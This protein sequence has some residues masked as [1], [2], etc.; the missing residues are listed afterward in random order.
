MHFDTFKFSTNVFKFA[1]YLSPFIPVT[2]LSYD[3]CQKLY[4]LYNL[5]KRNVNIKLIK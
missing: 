2:Y 5:V 3:L 1:I 4:E